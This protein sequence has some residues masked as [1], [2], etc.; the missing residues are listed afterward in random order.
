MTD[1]A[2][3]WL[4]VPTAGPVELIEAAVA[5]GFAA[6]GM[7]VVEPGETDE[8][9]VG[10]GGASIAS[11]TCVAAAAGVTIHRTSGFRLD[12]QYSVR[13]FDRFLEVSAALGA[14]Q[15]SV[16]A[17]DPERQRLSEAFADLCMNAAEYG[18]RVTIEFAP[19]SSVPT[20]G[21]AFE[22]LQ[23][24]EQCTASILL[25]ALHLFRSGGT[26]ADLAG[27]TRSAVSMIQ[28]CDARAAAPAHRDL[29]REARTDRLD[30]G[31]GALPLAEL[32]RA[33]PATLPLEVEIP[34]YAE[35]NL[36]PDERARRAARATRSFLRAIG[37]EDRDERP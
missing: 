1:L 13:R 2:L 28:L 21:A 29:L 23:Q 19:F 24:S 9:L 35:R 14:T 7:K 25:D 37:H 16:I 27:S 33:L 20:V 30:P 18:L 12:T 34:C 10:S 11:L 36:A 5:G 4:T 32:L 26:P 31:L 3:C 17:T 6:V 22:L 15:V 8:G